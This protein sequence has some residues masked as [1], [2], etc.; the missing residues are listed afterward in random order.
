MSRLFHPDQIVGMS[1]SAPATVGI[2]MYDATI[3]LEG[4]YYAVD[5]AQNSK[6][7]CGH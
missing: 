7:G 5:D 3:E 2:S 1:S 4:F 6:Y